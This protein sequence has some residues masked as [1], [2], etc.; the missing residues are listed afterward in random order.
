MIG[1]PFAME[2]LFWFRVRGLK[3]NHSAWIAIPLSPPCILSASV[4]GCLCEC[5]SLYVA[6]GDKIVVMLPQTF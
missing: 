4:C 3:G 6:Q 5:L 2:M 1:S